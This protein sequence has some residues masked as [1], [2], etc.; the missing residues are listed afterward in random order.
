MPGRVNKYQLQE[1]LNDV[2]DDTNGVIKTGV[3][4]TATIDSEFPPAGNL[5][6]D[7]QAAPTTTTIY[8]FPFVFNGTTWDRSSGY[9]TASVATF[10]AIAG[11]TASV[12]LQAANANRKKLIVANNSTGNLYIQYSAVA[13]TATSTYRLAAQAIFEMPDTVYSGVVTG[14]WDAVNG[15]AQVTEY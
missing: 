13:A 11:A 3:N 10:S 9:P 14:I 12:T 5:S 2:Y 1:I 6:A 8:S 7:A 4:L 15:I